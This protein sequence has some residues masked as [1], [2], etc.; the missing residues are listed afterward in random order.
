MI[1]ALTTPSGNRSALPPIARALPQAELFHKAIISLA[2][3]GKPADCPELVGRDGSG[4]PLQS[5]HGHAHTIPLDLLRND[6]RIDHLAVYAPNGLGALAQSA[7]KNLK[8][9]WTKGGAGEIQLALAAH[10][11]IEVLR[12]LQTGLNQQEK[13]LGPVGGSRVWETATPFVPARF[14]KSRGKNTLQGQVEAELASRGLPLPES[15][16]I[17]PELGIRLR[18]FIRRRIRGGTPPPIDAG[19]ALRLTFTEPVKGPVLLGYA[20]HFGLG[21]FRPIA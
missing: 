17:L 19:F 16:E 18:H 5:N 11:S 9:T 21:R 1:L 2:G 20:S 3:K 14:L 6:G 8:R 13:I 10:G 15:V 7:I 12:D 4:K